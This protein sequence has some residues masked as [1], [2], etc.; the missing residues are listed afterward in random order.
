[1]ARLGASFNALLTL[2]QLLETWTGAHK[3]YFR[4]KQNTK[5]LVYVKQLLSSKLLLINIFSLRNNQSTVKSIINNDNN[6]YNENTVVPIIQPKLKITD[7][8]NLL[9]I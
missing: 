5:I 2:E 3:N 7:P 4:F 8:A 9:T 1:M 6:L